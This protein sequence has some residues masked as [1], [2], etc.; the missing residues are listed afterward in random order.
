MKVNKK[1][2][3]GKTIHAKED[4]VGDKTSIGVMKFKTRWHPIDKICT[5]EKGI[6]PIRFGK[7]K[8]SIKAQ[9]NYRR[10]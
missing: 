5:C 8:E 7:Y 3:L 2:T 4:I 10:C 9:V 6:T 1:N